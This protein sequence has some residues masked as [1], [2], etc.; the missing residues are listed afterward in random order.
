MYRVDG[1]MFYPDRKYSSI[2]R[3]RFEDVDLCLQEIVQC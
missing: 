3:Y 2:D 1:S